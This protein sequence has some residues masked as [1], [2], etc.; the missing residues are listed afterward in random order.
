MSW[1]WAIPFSYLIATVLSTI[2][3]RVFSLGIIKSGTIPGRI[4]I[5]FD[6]GPDPV[7]TP[8]LLK[9][10]K[11]HDVK[12]TFFVVGEKA[13]KESGLIRTIH[14]DG[15]AIGLHNYKHVSNWFIMPNVLKKHLHQSREI[16]KNIIGVEP[17]FYRPPWGHFNAFT[18]LA[19]ADFTIIMWTAIPGDW[20]E[21]TGVQT[22]INRLEAARKD[23]AIITLHDCGTTFG[24]DPDAPKNMIE[25]LDLFLSKKES[26]K[27]T[28]V[29]V[30]EM[31]DRTKGN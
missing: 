9:V 31:M 29:T 22:L 5:T 3:I 14:E 2:I 4:A 28:Y 15:H 30:A 11:K 7:Y 27:Y 20:K 26:K 1:L 18:S 8:K 10:L 19:A 16:I 13:E 6:D 24:A 25:A 12:A 21:K 17:V 23:G